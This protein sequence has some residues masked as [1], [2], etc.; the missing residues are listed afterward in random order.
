MTRALK[1]CLLLTALLAGLAAL[2]AGAWVGV[3]AA[4]CDVLLIREEKAPGGELRAVVFSR[5]C[6]FDNSPNFQLSLF[7]PGEKLRDY[8]TG[9]VFVSEKDITFAWRSATELSVAGLGGSFH[10]T[11]TLYGH[12]VEHRD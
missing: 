5:S 11:K 3:N 6:A 8:D 9:N 12:H 1:L 10:V 4:L 7:E 2:A